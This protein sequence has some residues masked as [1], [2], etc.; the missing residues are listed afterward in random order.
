MPDARLREPL[1]APMAYHLHTRLIEIT[2]VIRGRLLGGDAGGAMAAGIDAML[3][4]DRHWLQEGRLMRLGGMA[5]EAI[6]EHE[7]EH[8]A[9]AGG[10]SAVVAALGR[11]DPPP[12]QVMSDLIDRAIEHTTHHDLPLL[13]RL[14]AGSRPEVL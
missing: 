8:A 9:F 12:D 14:M 3:A 5:P 2:A 10:L 6:A 4:L 7:S 13:S 11:G 1:T